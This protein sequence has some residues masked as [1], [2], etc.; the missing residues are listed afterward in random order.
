M[1]LSL[2]PVGD[3]NVLEK[4]EECGY[5]IGRRADAGTPSSVDTPPPA[6]ASLPLCSSWTCSCRSGKKAS[7]LVGEL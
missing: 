6:T 2:H 3:R 1:E 4:M 5:V 7:Q